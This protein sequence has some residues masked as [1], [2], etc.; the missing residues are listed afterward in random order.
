MAFHLRENVITF[1]MNQEGKWKGKNGKVQR[2]KDTG[3]S[4]DKK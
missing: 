3:E 4:T 1:Q 2:Q